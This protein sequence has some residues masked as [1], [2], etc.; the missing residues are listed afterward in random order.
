MRRI[1]AVVGDMSQEQDVAVETLGGSDVGGRSQ[2]GDIHY[3]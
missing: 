3:R 2:A 1:L